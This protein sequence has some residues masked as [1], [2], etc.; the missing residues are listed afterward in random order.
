MM[1]DLSDL[2]VGGVVLIH[3]EVVHQSAQNTSNVSRHAYAFHIM[4]SKDTRWSPDNWWAQGTMEDNK[5]VGEPQ[6]GIMAHVTSDCRSYSNLNSPKL[7]VILIPIRY[8][9]SNKHLELFYAWKELQPELVLFLFCPFSIGY[10]PPQS[11]LFLPSTPETTPGVHIHS[12]PMT[13]VDLGFTL[14]SELRL[15][16]QSVLQ[17]YSRSIKHKNMKTYRC[18]TV[19]R[20]ACS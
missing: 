15:K 13:I 11:C 3:G 10:S 7:N 6:L 20:Q 9:E 1:C 16:K 19:P 18:L 5:K 12:F 4:E 8:I 14:Y 2:P 17:A